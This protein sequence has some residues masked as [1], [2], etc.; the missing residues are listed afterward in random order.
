MGDSL[1][2]C[3]KRTWKTR[4]SISFIKYVVFIM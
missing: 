4:K 3:G 1:R 2:F